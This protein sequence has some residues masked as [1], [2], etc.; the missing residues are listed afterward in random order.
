M[1]NAREQFG[2]TFNPSAI[3]YERVRPS[4]PKGLIDDVISLSGMPNKGQILEIGCGTGK[5]TELFA[6][7]GYALDCLDI[8]KDL[9]SIAAEKFKDL[10]DIHINISSF[11]N[12]DASDNSYDLIISAASFHWV[13][14]GVR[15]NKS[16]ALLCETGA[17]AVFTNK[18]VKND[19]GF[20]ARVQ[21]V[22]Q[23]YAPSMERIKN[24]QRKLWVEP[25]TGEELFNEPIVRKYPWVEE[26][27]AD[28]YVALL[29][30]YSDHLSLPEEE[31]SSLFGR[32]A[33]LVHDEYAGIVCRHYEAVLTLR[34]L[35][36]NFKLEVQHLLID[37]IKSL[38]CNI[39]VSFSRPCV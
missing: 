14:P 32:I 31:R 18:L 24:E 19:E 8:G 25:V 9:A 2:K 17:L 22:Y 30:T 26:Y 21:D 7:R 15:F 1:N 10:E 3:L 4:Y 23:T 20:F 28:D 29:G 13:D 11:E 6:A 39:A 33:E 37:F 36:P 5:A 27:S 16:A 12:W 35:R 38:R 34:T